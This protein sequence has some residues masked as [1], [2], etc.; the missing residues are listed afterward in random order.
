MAPAAGEDGRSWRRWWIAAFAAVL[1][2]VALVALVLP[3]PPPKASWPDSLWVPRQSDGSIAYGDPR[4]APDG[5][6]ADRVTLTGVDFDLGH[7]F[8]ASK[9]P[10]VRETPH[11][12][13]G[14]K[15]GD[16][17]CIYARTPETEVRES[18]VWVRLARAPR[19]DGADR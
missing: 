10:F 12:I 14:R 4:L 9:R 3:S 11:R 6:P 13:L 16:E 19:S 15:T 1:G 5:P 2:A 17:W 7:A 8:Y 18:G